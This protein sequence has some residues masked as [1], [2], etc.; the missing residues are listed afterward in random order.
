M[1]IELKGVSKSYGAIGALSGISTTIPSGR[2]V[3]LIGPNGSGKSTLTRIMMGLVACEGDVLIEGCSPFDS[4]EALAARLAYVP[5]TAPQ[6]SAT[7]GEICKTIA[8]V[9]GIT[10]DAIESTAARLNFD[11]ASVARRPV[12]ALSGGMRQKLML[13]LALATRAELFILDEP[14][15]SLD[16]RSRDAFFR[17][18]DEIARD[19]TLILCSHRLEEIQN[20]VEHVIA[21]ENGS[22]AFDGPVADFLDARTVGVVEVY[23]VSQGRAD[24][25][26][27]R[28][29]A[30]GASGA[31]ARSVTRAEKIKLLREIAC[32]CNGDL[33]NIVVRDMES[34]ETEG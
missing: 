8:V 25:F 15:A 27:D 22:I 2:K 18:Y 30:P 7:V 10:R 23:E 9:R 31:W 26:K 1:R 20:L 6:L 34:V 29:F 3:A 14:T 4:R 24:W 11:I 16:A 33:R 13:S 5:Q 17:I 12:R 32:A 19:A 21:L 28:G